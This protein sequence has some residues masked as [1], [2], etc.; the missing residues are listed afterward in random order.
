MSKSPYRPFKPNPDQ[1]ALL[2]SISGNEINGV[3]ESQFRRA[4]PIYWHDPESLHHGELQKWFYT[5]NPDNEAIDKAQA[6]TQLLQVQP[7]SSIRR[8]IC[9]GLY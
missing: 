3:G 5:Q 6:L 9:A 8:T 7:T 4:A 2:P 1:I